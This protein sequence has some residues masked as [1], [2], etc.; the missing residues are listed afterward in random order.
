MTV[1]AC[2]CQ[3]GGTQVFV[4]SS[5]LSES[6]YSV[7]PVGTTNKVQLLCALSRPLS[8]VASS[9]VLALKNTGRDL[10]QFIYNSSLS[11]LCLKKKCK[12]E[13]V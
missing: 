7:D 1:V 12:N 13:T 11:T 2:V 10:I 5:S 6:H 3:L 4:W 9:A 8:L